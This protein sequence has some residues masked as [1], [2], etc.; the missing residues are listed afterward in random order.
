MVQL[1]R[2]QRRQRVPRAARPDVKLRA[3]PALMLA[4]APLHSVPPTN[5]APT[6]AMRARWSAIPVAQMTDAHFAVID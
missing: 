1:R 2:G 6:N 5:I 3:V 4:W